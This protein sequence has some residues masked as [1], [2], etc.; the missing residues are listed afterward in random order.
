MARPAKKIVP[1][2]SKPDEVAQSLYAKREKI[3]PREVHGL[4]AMW[5]TI[6]VVALLGIYYGLPWFRWEGRQAVL[7]DLPARKFYI[8]GLT[9][10]PQD[11]FYFAVLL[12]I[13]A[14][15]LFFFTALAG[16][17][18]CGY[19][20]PQS[21]WTD[22]FLRIERWIEGDRLRQ[23]TLDTAPWSARKI[24]VKGAK[25]T[26]WVL[27]AAYTGFTFVG[28]FTP[29]TGLTEKITA[30]ALGPWET[31]WII[32]YSLATYGNAGWLREQVCIYMCPYARFQGAM[33]DN[34]TLII[35]YDPARGELRG[36]RRKSDDY[37]AKGLGECIDCTMCVQVCPTGIDI[38]GGLQYECIAC[39]ACVDVCNQVMEKMDYP[40]GLIRYTTENAVQ[41]NPSHLLRPRVLVYT[42]VLLGLFSLMGFGLSQRVPLELHAQRDRNTLYR[43]TLDGL[44]ENVYT[45]QIVNMD[46][47]AHEY[48]L[49]VS[50]INDMQ[51]HKNRE[52]ITVPGGEVMEFP[53]WL[54]ADP[55]GLRRRST[56][57]TFE[58]R[59]TD[60]ATL[61]ARE[62]ARFL[63]PLTGR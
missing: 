21:V 19:A 39:A 8:F 28:Y 11:F 55:Q 38:R 46:Q 15:S 51:L 3:Y 26:V 22:V 49:S 53:V 18:W 16:R 13:A 32:F 42:V 4:F 61:I 54:R 9:F 37:K 58:V 50:G 24:L 57:I 5:R 30:F 47:K 27:F 36:S 45:L 52:T 48:E 59:A 12:I 29:I 56:A 25:H 14:L 17:L 43:E 6:G 63:G 10:W 34:D 41:G 31:F 35:S 1:L 20:C 60:D 62:E 2:N 33:F 7:L 44:L 23:M 40:K